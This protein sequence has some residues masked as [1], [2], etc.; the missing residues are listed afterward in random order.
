MAKEGSTLEAGVPWKMTGIG[1]EDFITDLRRAAKSDG[2]TV[3][4]KGAPQAAAKYR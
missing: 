2:A 1:L 3:N 4:Q